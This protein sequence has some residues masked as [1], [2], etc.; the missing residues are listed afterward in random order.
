MQDRRA[1][2]RTIDWSQTLL[3]LV[4]VSILAALAYVSSAP[5]PRQRH[6][7]SEWIVAVLIANLILLAIQY[8]AA[9]PAL[10]MGAVAMDWLATA[11][12]T[13]ITGGQESPFLGLLLIP[14]LLAAL[15]LRPRHALYCAIATA[16]FWVVL[17]VADAR[18]VPPPAM[19]VVLGRNLLLLAFATALVS[20]HSATENRR[21]AAREREADERLRR[22]SEQIKAIYELTGNLSATLNYQRVLES[23]LEIGVMGLQEM[24]AASEHVLGMVLLF[25]EGNGERALRIAAYRH[26]PE[27]DAARVFR[28]ESGLLGQIIKA[29][30]PAV[31]QEPEKDPELGALTALRGY[32]SAAAIPLRAGFELYGAA[33]FADKQRGL[34]QADQ[35]AFLSTLCSQA[36]IALQNARLYRQLQEEKER[37]IGSE[38]ELR[39]WLARELHDGPTQTISALAMRLNYAR[40]LVQREPD[41][42]S[43]EL[44]D[45]EKMA[46][47][48]TREIRTTLFKL[49]PLALETQGLAGALQQYVERL[50]ET[51]GTPIL[52]DIEQPL[53]RL[54]I[55]VEGTIFSIVEEAVNNACKHAEASLITV[56]LA[57]YGDM[58]VVMVHD[59]GHGFDVNAIEDTYDQRDSLGLINMRERAGLIGARLEIESAPGRGTTITLALPLN[60]PA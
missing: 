41:K 16:I 30:E 45:L 60:P 40:L 31:I 7:L 46:R 6:L 29:V 32:T 23:V 48:A 14:V 28:G 12:L 13:L 49:R 2:R 4:F 18:G 34:Y 9:S 26:L 10:A 55:N 24:D 43:E 33:V 17:A 20:W 22:V 38:T 8:L 51:G 59:N 47:R 37:I 39:H 5:S 35:V 57:A 58:L 3:R 27:C 53:E 44:L 56:R 15:R 50:K 25:G 54:D 19:L 36:T 52:L 1:G 11:A 21:M 42:A